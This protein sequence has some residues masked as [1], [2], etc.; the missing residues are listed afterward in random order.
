MKVL[1][2]D[3]VDRTR[4][5]DIDD[6]ASCW[7]VPIVRPMRWLSEQVDPTQSTYEVATFKPTGEH[8]VRLSASGVAS[9]PIWRR[10]L[11][12]S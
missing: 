11:D 12:H 10:L 4:L 3:G 1:L 9:L 8:Q 7:Y 5:M 6:S 2:I